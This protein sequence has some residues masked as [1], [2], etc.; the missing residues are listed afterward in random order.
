MRGSGR[1]SGDDVFLINRAHQKGRVEV[2]ADSEAI[3]ATR[4]PKSWKAL[5]VQ[6]ARWWQTSSYPAGWAILLAALITSLACCQL[7]LLALPVLPACILHGFGCLGFK[8]L[9]RLLY[10]KEVYRNNRAGNAA[11]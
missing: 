4:A 1:L 11:S 6:R 9:R 5:L 7:A 8:G 10:P 2:V 3:V